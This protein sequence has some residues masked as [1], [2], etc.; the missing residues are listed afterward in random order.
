MATPDDLSA[1]AARYDRFARREAPGRSELYR[2]WAQRIATEPDLT[3]VVAGIPVAH[4][5]PPLVFAVMRLLGAPEAT[6]EAWAG[7]LR[8]HAAAV[9]AE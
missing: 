3:A 1:T 4:R 8:G 5:Q 9:Q 6:G 7:W 2:G